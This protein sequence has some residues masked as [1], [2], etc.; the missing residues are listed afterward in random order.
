MSNLTSPPFL[1]TLSKVLGTPFRRVL[2]IVSAPYAVWLILS[3]PSYPLLIDLFEDN[4]YYAE[5]MHLTGIW[6]IQLLVL[7][8]AVTPFVLLVKRWE[9]GRI[10]GRWLLKNRRYFGVASFGYAFLHVVFYIRGTGS[11]YNI[12]LEAFDI[13][14]ATGWIGFVL[15]ILLFATSNN[16]SVRRLGQKW[17]NL[18]RL[19]YPATV[20]IFIHWFYFEFFWSD[21][22]DWLI[23]LVIA[24][25]IH[26]G[27]RW[28]TG[29]RTRM[30]SRVNARDVSKNNAL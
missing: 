8:L 24:K 10:V 7:T 22:I 1:D 16:E 5:I 23:V 9:T 13:A 4:R 28:R 18:Q 3:L 12:Y 29:S 19:I 25:L 21:V 14:F 17:K 15:L 2:A 26:L 6:S 27:L 20:A 11:L 30:D